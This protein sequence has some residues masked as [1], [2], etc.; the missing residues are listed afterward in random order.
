MSIIH[1]CLYLVVGLCIRDVEAS[2]PVTSNIT[3]RMFSFVGLYIAN[4]VTLWSRVPLQKLIVTQLVTKY[5][6]F[7]RNPKFIPSSKRPRDIVLVRNQ[8]NV[9]HT[10]YLFRISFNIIIPYV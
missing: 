3:W 4:K 7:C 6:V 10:I 1:S 2:G 8:M 5:S 9:V